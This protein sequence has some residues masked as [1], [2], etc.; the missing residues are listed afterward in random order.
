MITLWAP[1]GDT[2]FLTAALESQIVLE[3]VTKAKYECLRA[4]WD[5]TGKRVLGHSAWDW[6]SE[7]LKTGRWKGRYVGSLTS[8]S[9][10]PELWKMILSIL[11]ILMLDYPPVGRRK[12]LPDFWGGEFLLLSFFLVVL[13]LRSG[14]LLYLSDP[15][16]FYMLFTGESWLTKLVWLMM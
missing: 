10:Y 16:N 1:I 13:G 7:S 11:C 8:L 9:W 5:R 15:P 2:C 4:I 6:G 3:G 12:S 14:V